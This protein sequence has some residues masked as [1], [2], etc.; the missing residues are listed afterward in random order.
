MIEKIWDLCP[1]FGK[2]GTADA[3]KHSPQLITRVKCFVFSDNPKY[4]LPHDIFLLQ[5]S[6]GYGS[7]ESDFVDMETFPTMQNDTASL[8]ELNLVGQVCEDCF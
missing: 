5:G 2:H 4:F 3:G 7:T 8:P 1:V 6:Q